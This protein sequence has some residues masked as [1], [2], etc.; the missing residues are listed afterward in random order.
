MKVSSLILFVFSLSFCSCN[1]SPK[2]NHKK[3]GTVSEKPANESVE[4]YQD[5]TETVI[6]EEEITRLSNVIDESLN[7]YTKKDTVVFG[8]SSEGTE[9][10]AYYDDAE[11]KKIV[12]KHA[13]EYGNLIEE[14]YFEKGKLIFVVFKTTYYDKPIFDKDIP[15]TDSV[16]TEYFYFNKEE[17]I[18]WK[19]NEVE[20]NREENNYLEKAKIL[21]KSVREY[22]ISLK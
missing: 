12:A 22:L 20:A 2:N 6:T 18:N 10:I 8:Y 1:G 9:L 13:G 3:E 11:I 17:L 14:D 16:T 5:T 21:T 7:N 4:Q 19:Q 15:K